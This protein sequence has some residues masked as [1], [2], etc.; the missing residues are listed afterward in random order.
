MLMFVCGLK[1]EKI[2]KIDEA[3][4]VYL[5]GVLLCSPCGPCYTE[6]LFQKKKREEDIDEDAPCGDSFRSVY[7]AMS[8]NEA[9]SKTHGAPKKKTTN[10]IS[11]CPQAPTPPPT[12]KKSDSSATITATSLS[13][14]QLKVLVP[15]KYKYV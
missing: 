10:H 12:K 13:K 9:L 11:S 6:H 3:P 15:V 1:L 4:E 14:L 8:R 2:L 5:V 7:M